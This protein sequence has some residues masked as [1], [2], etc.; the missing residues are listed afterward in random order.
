MSPFASRLA[1]SALAVAAA[2]GLAACERKP[3]DPPTPTTIRI[4][5]PAQSQPRPVDLRLMT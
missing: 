4:D 1:A 5:A 2:S 3:S